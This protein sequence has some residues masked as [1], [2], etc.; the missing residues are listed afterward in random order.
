MSNFGGRR[1]RSWCRTVKGEGKPNAWAVGAFNRD[2]L[3][4]TIWQAI[5]NANGGALLDDNNKPAFNNDVG[6]KGTSLQT[7]VDLLQIRAAGR[8]RPPLS[9]IDAGVPSGPR[10]R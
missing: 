6:V 2:P 10:P 8:D 1:R 5:L 4:P 9:K 7:H 3:T